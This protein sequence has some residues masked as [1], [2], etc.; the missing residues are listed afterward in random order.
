ME[1]AGSANAA[2]S[3]LFKNREDGVVVVGD[4]QGAGLEPYVSAEI[5][6]RNG[7]RKA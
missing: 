5:L 3:M 2:E 6:H 7:H 1:C 4:Q